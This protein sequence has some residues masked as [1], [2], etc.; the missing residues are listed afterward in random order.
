VYGFPVGQRV[1]DHHEV[2]LPV[3]RKPDISRDHDMGAFRR[4]VATLIP[5]PASMVVRRG[6]RKDGMH[7]RASGPGAFV[8][9]IQWYALFDKPT[10]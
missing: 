8:A 4:R 10:R 6:K 9:L 2:A 5:N 1:R 7:G 3:G